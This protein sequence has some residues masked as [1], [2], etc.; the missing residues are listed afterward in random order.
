MKRIFLCVAVIVIA[1]NSSR[2]SKASG[3]VVSLSFG[4]DPAAAE[5]ARSAA[6][7]RAQAQIDSGHP[8]RATQ[9]M[10]P[11]LRDSRQRTPAALLVAARAAAGWDGWSEVEK[12]LAKESWLDAQFEGEGRELLTR[13]ALQRGADTVARTRAVA[14]LRDAK[15]ETTR[16]VRL[17][18]FARALERNNVFDSAAAAYVRAAETLKPVRSWLYLRAAG[19]E[20]DSA[21]RAALFANVTLAPA[22]PRTAWTEAQARERFSDALGAASRFAA[23]GSTV[24]ALRLRLSVAPDTATRNVVKNE[25]LGVVRARPNT[26]DA[27]SAVDVLDR[28]FTSF[29]PAEELA[30]ARGTSTYTPARAVTGFA[31]AATLMTPADGMAY[32]QALARLGRSREALAQLQMVHGP[33]AGQAAYQRSRILL[34]SGTRDATLAALRA[35]VTRFPADTG[36][37]SAALFLLA[38]LETDTGNDAG[39]RAIYQR[40][41]RTY[42]SS[43]RA[44]NARFNA[45]IIAFAGGN[46]AVAAREFDSLFTLLP[47]SDETIAA[48]FWSGRAWATAGNPALAKERWQR[49]I[50]QQPMSYYAFASGRRLGAPAWTPQGEPESVAR[51]PAVDSAVARIALLDRLGM[52]V[53]ARFEYDALDESAGASPE[54]LAA[55]AH[56]LAL[57]GEASRAIRLAQKLVDAGHRDVNTYRLLYP[58]FDRDELSRDAKTNA[59]DPVLVAALIRQESAFNP[60]AVSVAGARG[61]MQVLPAVGE[62]VA[63]SLTYPVWYPALLFDPDANLQL[64]TAHLAMFIKRHGALPR[65]LA[66]Y[67]AGGSR[68]TRWATKAGANDPELFAERIPFAE[69]RDYVR[70][71]QRNAEIYRQIYEW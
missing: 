33:L 66:A 21:R 65:V 30:I 12:L 68:V 29:A 11:V 70:I 38:D 71:V 31:R 3:E 44:A 32:A 41:Y 27:R 47:R 19:S 8:W 6:L 64:G 17:T 15:L 59:L 28:G 54:R 16:A 53:E 25:L 24:Q 4:S 35:T 20:V 50:A 58:L 34:A 61:L 9:L 69:T 57:R 48:L 46:T 23:L 36:A 13:S 39:A 22:K 43:A 26:A 7:E 42:P 60:R 52:D 1:C 14:A 2:D 55:T 40:L 63:R 49:V 10:A 18:L 45:A 62:E 51:V 37:A 56:A 67:N 5:I